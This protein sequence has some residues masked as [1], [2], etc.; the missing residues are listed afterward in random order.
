[1]AVK[2]GK[3]KSWLKKTADLKS[4]FEPKAGEYIAKLIKFHR[5]AHFK[6]PYGGRGNFKFFR[7]QLSFDLAKYLQRVLP[8]D[9]RG[10]VLDSGAG[11]LGISNDIKQTFGNRVFVT[12]LNV[13]FPV[14]TKKIEQELSKELENLRLVRKFGFNREY[15]KLQRHLA[16]LRAVKQRTKSVKDIRVGAIENF[17]NKRKYDVIIDASG[18][19]KYTGF[20]S[21]VM[22]VYFKSLNPNGVIVV[23]G[24][25]PIA[26]KTVEREFGPNSSRARETGYYFRVRKLAKKVIEIKKVP[27]PKKRS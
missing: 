5:R 25:I 26:Q 6:V 7:D 14:P 13:T 20:P 8:K 9:R 3:P 27:V 11:F 24:S 4:E 10:R 21:R 22:E 12:A 17:S 18:G 19:L 1:M 23:S 2:R 15:L 16:D